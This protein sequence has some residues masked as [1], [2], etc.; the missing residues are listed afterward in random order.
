MKRNI[1]I[2]CIAFALILTGSLVSTAIILDNHY[3]QLLETQ[4]N[5]YRTTIQ[6]TTIKYDTL[7]T[8]YQSLERQFINYQSSVIQSQIEQSQSTVPSLPE[9]K[10]P[11]SGDWE[12]YVYDDICGSP[13]SKYIEWDIFSIQCGVPSAKGGDLPFCSISTTVTNHHP[14]LSVA[15]IS[16]NGIEIAS[17]NPCAIRIDPN[18]NCTFVK[19][20]PL[21]K[22]INQQL[23]LK[24]R[25]Q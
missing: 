3:N 22:Y 16:I 9:I 8:D 25:W 7:K 24:W 13:H 21:D 20:I 10:E 2:L 12:T 15:D 6:A 18:R 11:V 19:S 17:A 14:N 23:V 1:I 4:A 5:Q